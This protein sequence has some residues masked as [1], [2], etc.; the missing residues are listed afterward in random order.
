MFTPTQNTSPD[1]SLD[2]SP[3]LVARRPGLRLRD[4]RRALCVM[5]ATLAAVPLLRHFVQETARPWE[6][7]DETDDALGVVA[8]ELVANVVRHSGSQDVAVLLTV[9]G[10]TVTLHVQDTGRWRPRRPRLSGDDA[11]AC[12][13][14]GL[15][16][17]RAYALECAIVRTA[18]G[19]RV[20]VTLAADAAIERRP[21]V[22]D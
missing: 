4:E 6:L 22:P 5:P 3:G 2:H 15:Q 11:A 1:H 10:R 12:C 17:V 13:G 20:S 21:P 8:T 18:R 7:G 16:L 14:R 9:T 19:T